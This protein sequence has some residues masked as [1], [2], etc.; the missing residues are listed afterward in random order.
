MRQRRI[1]E[2]RKWRKGVG[3]RV[4][5]D[6][7]LRSPGAAAVVVVAVSVAASLTG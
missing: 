7:I 6:Q 1:Q 3:G 4:R 2:G 5:A